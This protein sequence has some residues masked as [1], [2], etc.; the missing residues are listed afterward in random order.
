MFEEGRRY[1]SAAAFIDALYG[2]RRRSLPTEGIDIT[3]MAEGQPPTNTF[4]SMKADLLACKTITDLFKLASSDEFKARVSSLDATGVKQLRAVYHD[5]QAQLDGQ[6]KMDDLDGQT[7]N[8]V[9]LEWWQSD[10]GD[11]VTIHFHTEREPE[12]K[13]KTRTSSAPVVTFSTRIREVPT[14][15]EPVR[16]FFQKVPVSDAK[17]AAEGQKKWQVRRLPPLAKGME[18]GAPF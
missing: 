16:A 8:I 1:D 17:R 9:G 5:Q 7:I 12:K 4:E 2:P 6:V 15:K 10:Y 3:I 18:G 11:G 14:E 13:Y